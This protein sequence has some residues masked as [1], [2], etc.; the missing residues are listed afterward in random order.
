MREVEYSKLPEYQGFEVLRPE[1]QEEFL[2]TKSRFDH[3]EYLR[4]HEGCEVYTAC[5]ESHHNGDYYG[6]TLVY[7]SHP[8]RPEGV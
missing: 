3:C 7:R 8:P 6:Q 5:Y 4:N 1:N 2:K